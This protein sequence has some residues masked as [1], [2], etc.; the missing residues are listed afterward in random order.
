MPLDQKANILLVDDSP[1]NLLAL[2][3]V[4]EVLGQNL[5]LASSGKEALRFLLDHEVAIILL[6]VQMPGM[7]GFETAELIRT[8]ER[9]RKT[10]IVFQTAWATDPHRVARGYA[11]GAV[12]YV[13]KPIDPVVLRSKVAVFLDLQRKT[14][15]L[16]KKN[17]ELEAALE[18]TARANQFKSWFLASVSHE[19]RTPLGGI[20]G[21]AELLADGLS[22]PLNDL[23]REHTG[24]VLRSAEHLAALV[25]DL[26]DLS[27]IEAGRMEIAPRW[28]ALETMTAS[29]VS[30]L[31]T[32][33]AKAGVELEVDIPAKFPDL[34]VDPLRMRQVLFN[35]VSNAIKFSPSGSTTTIRAA[36]EPTGAAIL[37]EDHGIG[38]PP[39]QVSR[40]F[41][42][43]EQVHQPNG[44]NRPIG[45]G[46]GLSVTRHLVELHEGTID[47]D[48]AL[49]RGSLFT[50]HLPARRTRPSV[51]T[52]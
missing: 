9:S 15:A 10:P 6:D 25:D 31:Q 14:Q 18:Q 23:Q 45:T 35:L 19:L 16:E 33:A 4:L 48:T 27:K 21:F 32:V 29:V 11:I 41:R 2:E 52:P 46:L 7:D 37:V 51:Q 30:A 47:V 20:L 50:V 1:A 24:Q 17:I 44:S 3:A 39:E 28:T 13:A 43:F 36:M 42:E 8:R 5:V 34:N 26:L 22:G 40:L 12:D 49:G 38:I